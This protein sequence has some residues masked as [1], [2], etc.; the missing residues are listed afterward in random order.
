MP[1]AKIDP[2]APDTLMCAD[3]TTR[4]VRPLNGN[5]YKLQELYE[6]LG[7]RTVEVVYT[8]VKDLILICDEES[9][10]FDAKD[11]TQAS[12]LAGQSIVGTALACH[13]K[14]FK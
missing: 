13:T 7:C 2:N 5:S 12:N 3:G 4:V 8:P 9:R 1:R 10:V 11:N 6:L 14:R